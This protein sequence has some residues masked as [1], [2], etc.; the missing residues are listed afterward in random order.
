MSDINSFTV[1]GV[2]DEGNSRYLEFEI[3]TSFHPD[4]AN[5]SIHVGKNGGDVIFSGNVDRGYSDI[6]GSSGLGIIE[7]ISGSKY[8]IKFELPDQFKFPEEGIDT[9]NVYGQNGASGDYHSL[10][11]SA[12]N[13]TLPGNG[14][15]TL[16]GTV[17]NNTSNQ[18]SGPGLSSPTFEESSNQNS[19]QSEI[20][21]SANIIG[22]VSALNHIA[23]TLTR[24][25]S[26]S[27]H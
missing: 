5:F 25:M 24:E 15:L 11:L 3:D 19:S 22:D 6:W 26:D 13:G 2:S 7:L 18:Y 16:N 1:I 20:Y 12:D 14:L 27:T 8:S 23:Y 9:I 4:V 17:G 10:Y 21:L